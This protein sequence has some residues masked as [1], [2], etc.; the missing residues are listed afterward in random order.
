MT[1]FSQL[2]YAMD[3]T[4]EEIGMTHQWATTK[5]EA[6]IPQPP[7]SYVYGGQPSNELLM[8]WDLERSEKK[9]DAYRRQQTLTYTDSKTGLEVRC[10]V[11][12]TRE[13]LKLIKLW[14]LS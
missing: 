4:H 5:F 11:V 10:V 13:I 8:T 6:K 3:V 1:T 12:E 9:L 7:F 14:S 2:P